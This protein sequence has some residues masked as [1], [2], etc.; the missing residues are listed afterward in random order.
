M[1]CITNLNATVIPGLSVDLR[2]DEWKYISLI[3]GQI[4]GLRCLR[5]EKGMLANMRVTWIILRKNKTVIHVLSV[6]LSGDE[7]VISA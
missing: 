2:G 3:M 1:D 6:D 5:R 4:T 7:R